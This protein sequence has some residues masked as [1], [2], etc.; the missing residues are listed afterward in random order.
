VPHSTQWGRVRR[1]KIS[2]HQKRLAYAS[3]ADQGARFGP[4]LPKKKGGSEPLPPQSSNLRDVWSARRL[5]AMALFVLTILVAGTAVAG[6]AARILRC[7]AAHVT[8]FSLGEFSHLT[9][10]SGLPTPRIKASI[11][12][13]TTAAYAEI[14]R[15]PRRG[16]LCLLAIPGFRLPHT[17][18]ELR[19][20]RKGAVKTAP[21]AEFEVTDASTGISVGDLHLVRHN[22]W[23][24]TQE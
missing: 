20:Q 24:G 8:D 11:A 18:C 15:G 19:A 12:N 14:R 6:P 3:D 1:R 10:P 16:K 17:S 7:A 5:P 9:Y 2:A 13:A 21:E 4:G 23:S 22:S